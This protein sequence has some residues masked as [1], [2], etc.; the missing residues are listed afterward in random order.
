MSRDVWAEIHAHLTTGL[1]EATLANPTTTPPN[2]VVHLLQTQPTVLFAPGKTVFDPSC[3]VG[4]LLL[5]VKWV[6]VLVHEMTEQQAVQDLYGCDLDRK[7]LNIARARLGGGTLIL[8][9]PS[10]PNTQVPG[11]TPD[12]HTQLLTLFN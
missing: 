5:G 9:D 10:N 7:N 6:K 8:G 1:D 4:Q 2:V 3:G 12:E 11:Q